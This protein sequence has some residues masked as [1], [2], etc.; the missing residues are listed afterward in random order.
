[1]LRH[2]KVTTDLSVLGVTERNTTTAASSRLA[3]VFRWGCSWDGGDGGGSTGGVAVGMGG[4]GEH[5]P[6][7]VPGSLD[8][9]E[10]LPRTCLPCAAWARGWEL[11]TGSVCVS[12]HVHVRGGCGA[13]DTAAPR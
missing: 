4:M 6:H 5:P 7:L 11:L 1:M 2:L 10:S 12:V 9:P 8:T 13:G 3:L